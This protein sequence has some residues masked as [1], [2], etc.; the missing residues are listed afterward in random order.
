MPQTEPVTPFMAATPGVDHRILHDV[1]L[2]AEGNL[3]DQHDPRLRCSGSRR[4]IAEQVIALL[5]TRHS[6]PST[7]LTAAG[8]H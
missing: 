1:G 3:V 5:S 7:K 6:A 2:D 8:R 4:G